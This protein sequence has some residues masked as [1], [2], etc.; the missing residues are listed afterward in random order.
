VAGA[1]GL[2][3]EPF[4]YL[5]MGAKAAGLSSVG[6]DDV[7]EVVRKHAADILGKKG[8]EIFAKGL[9]RALGV[10]VS[11]RMGLDSLIAFGE[12][13]SD[14]QTDVKS[15][16]FD[17]LAG[18]PAALVGDYVKGANQLAV[19]NFTKAAELMVP[20]KFAADSI[21]AYRTATEG[22]KS[23]NGRQVMEPY[24]WPEAG[25]RA[26]GFTPARE[27]ESGAQYAA[28]KNQTT[29]AQQARTSLINGWVNAK[30][31]DKVQAQRAVQ[32]FN[33][34]APKDQQISAK[35]LSTAAKRRENEGVGLV[36]NKRTEATKARLEQ[37]YQ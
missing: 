23:D 2:P 26:L 18:A 10:D 24:S 27:A 30:G 12:P 19:G 32:A 13:K 9:P 6:W 4:K 11:S 31:A 29:K 22:K 3:T 34:T 28:F 37:I 36:A 35:D 33:R 1:L 15:W 5:L 16:L 21:R 14:K 8:G 17:T 7:E 20:M 25:A